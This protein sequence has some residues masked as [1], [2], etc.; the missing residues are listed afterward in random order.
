MGA[1]GIVLNNFNN[2]YR[3]TSLKIKRLHHKHIKDEAFRES[4]SEY[5]IIGDLIQRD[6]DKK[7][8]KT[9]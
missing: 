8:K 7:I 9:Q 2:D 6:I 5:Q 3:Y 1:Y 4:K